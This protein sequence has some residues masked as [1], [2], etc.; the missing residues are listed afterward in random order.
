M[1]HDS[2]PGGSDWVG[3]GSGLGCL[4]AAAAV[5]LVGGLNAAA[6]TTGGLMT[7]PPHLGHAMC[8]AMLTGDP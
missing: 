6:F 3:V 1:R 2:T 7:A 8:Q 5:T 4:S